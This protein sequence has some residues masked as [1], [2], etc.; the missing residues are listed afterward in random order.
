MVSS[1]GSIAPTSLKLRLRTTLLVPFILQIVAAVGLVGYLSF[2]NGQQAVTDLANQ[3]M[4]EVN[5]RVA[6]HLDGYLK[7]PH[8]INQINIDA[9]ETGLLN[10][11]DFERAGRY[12]S[13]QVQVFDNVGFISYGLSDGRFIGAGEFLKGKGVTIDEVSA[14][15]NWK[16]LLQR[17]GKA[18]EKLL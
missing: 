16:L 1:K 12:F 6:Q 8:Q 17:Y 15:T 7:T 4:N 18:T 13:K 2:R 11:E 14:K 5:N 9:I 3:L 10:L